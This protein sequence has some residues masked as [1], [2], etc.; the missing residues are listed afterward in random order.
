[1]RKDETASDTLSKAL[2]T[3]SWM[4]KSME[5][6]DSICKV[7]KEDIEVL[8]QAFHELQSSNKEL[9]EKLIVAEGDI[10]AMKRYQQNIAMIHHLS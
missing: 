2:S 1:M 10:A 5:Y 7:E 9:E 4:H 8:L 3:I 6:F